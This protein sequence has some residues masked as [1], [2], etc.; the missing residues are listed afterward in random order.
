MPK[1]SQA[2]IAKIVENSQVLQCQAFKDPAQF[3][4]KLHNLQFMSLNT[5][6]RIHKV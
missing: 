1:M 2:Q 5:I 3:T 6:G 4:Q